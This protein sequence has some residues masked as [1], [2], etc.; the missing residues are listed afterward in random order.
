MTISA[1]GPLSLHFK[2]RSIYLE[3][4]NGRGSVSERPS[5]RIASNSIAG[6]GGLTKYGVD[7]PWLGLQKL[8]PKLGGKLYCF[9]DEGGLSGLIKLGGSRRPAGHGNTDLSK[10][11]FLT[12]WR[13]DAK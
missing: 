4:A 6:V 7:R 9:G 2:S 1:F 10:K 11:L 8:S 13:A 5:E 12:G 3:E